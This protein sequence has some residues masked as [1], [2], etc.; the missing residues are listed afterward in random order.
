MRIVETPLFGAFVV[1]V[2]PVVDELCGSFSRTFDRKPFV[3]HGLYGDYAQ[4]SLSYN[5]KRGTLRGLHFQVDPHA[6]TKLV[7]CVRGAAWDV[8]VDL[9]QASSTFKRWHAVELTAE[10]RRAVYVP[11]GFAH[12]FITLI[13]DT[14]LHYQITPDAR[15]AIAW[16]AASRWND[17]ELAIAW[18]IRA[19]QFF[20]TR[21][22]AW[23]ALAEH[24]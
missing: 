17:L 21:D 24:S 1:E 22:R 8:M 4:G 7:R 5:K 20:R 23:P 16:R 18:P 3:D 12:G 9:R 10:N 19:E 11:A 14:E 2:D 15:A 13:D 6:E